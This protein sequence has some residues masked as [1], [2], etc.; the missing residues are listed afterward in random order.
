MAGGPDDAPARKRRAES[1]L[2]IHFDFHAGKDCTEVGRDVTPAMIEDICRK[3]RPDYIQCDCKGHPGISS[4]PTK[5]G[6]P[7]PGFV[8]DPLR[9]WRDVTAA[10]GVALYMHYSGVIDA[11]QCRR[12]PEWAR[13]GPDGT[14]DD[15]EGKR[16]AT[17]VFGPYVDEVLIPQFKELVDD[18]G[19]DGVWVD[20]ECWGTELDYCEAALEEFR[21]STGLDAAP[22]GPDDPGWHE[23]REINRERF[24]KYLAHYVDAMHDH[25]PGFQIAS[26]WAYSH[27]MPE[28]VATNVDFI[29]GDYSMQNSVNA[30]RFAGR[31]MA[32]QG[33]PWDLMAWSFASRWGEKARSTKTVP[34]LCRE[35]AVVLALGAGSRPTS[36]R[37]ATARYTPGRW[38]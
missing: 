5:V 23:F 20:G 12:H 27:Q 11:E 36:S 28:K 14:P 29:S 32:R 38:T 15:G 22:K 18:Y 37:N 3:V 13:V 8:R 4:Y 19:V 33:R 21:R 35:A 2:G 25:A 34:Q 10:R 1:F 7:A 24:R 26:N 30:A 17:S 6:A 9:I 31:V 16:H